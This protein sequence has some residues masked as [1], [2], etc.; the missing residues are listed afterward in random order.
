MGSCGY[1]RGESKAD[2]NLPDGPQWEGM[3]PEDGRSRTSE[4][5]FLVIEVL[6]GT[7]FPR[8]DIIGYCDPYI[9]LSVKRRNGTTTGYPLQCSDF[10]VETSS[11]VWHCY[12]NCGP[13]NA[14]DYLTIKTYDYDWD[15]GNDFI[16]AVDIPISKI[17]SSPCTFEV[18]NKKDKQP[19]TI[20][21][22]RVEHN[23]SQTSKTIFLVR[24]GESKWNA[25]Q[26]A[27]EFGKMLAYDHALNKVGINQACTLNTSWGEEKK[28]HDSKEHNS[29]NNPGTLVTQF[30]EAD[31]VFTSPLTR[32]LQTCLLALEN[33][34]CVASNGVT[35]L[36]SVRERK[37]RGGLDTVGIAIGVS[38]IKA[39][40]ID[41]LRVE[42][43]EEKFAEKKSCLNV[44]L[45]EN[46]TGQIWWTPKSRHDSPKRLESRVDDFLNAM[47]FMDFR[48][49]I[50]AGHSLFFRELCKSRMDT[51]FASA[52]PKFA[53]ELKSK[54]MN[55]GA[56]LAITLDFSGGRT[57]ITNYKFMFGTSFAPTSTPI[58]KTD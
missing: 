9:T 28:K 40:A 58:S 52:H 34:P 8:T 19:F 53:A 57:T 45:E 37:G 14:N 27:H 1:A 30:L 4:N 38:A 32:A 25:A 11:P 54:K 17:K 20:T 29:S 13:Y 36:P 47:Q 18:G 49:G 55:N 21:L 35:L 16:S 24:H 7:G 26:Q 46:G 22:R 6:S 44:K 48:R 10:K 50:V 3:L 41:E 2:Q 5:K 31:Q 51:S 39:R 15:S 56:C 42:L 43:G 12:R 33:H 23:F